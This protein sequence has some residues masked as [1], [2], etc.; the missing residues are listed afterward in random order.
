MPDPGSPH[1]C[2]QPDPTLE[3]SRFGVTASLD[4]PW[5][6]TVN[7]YW[8]HTANGT[9]ISKP[10][11]EYREQVIR[12]VE[13]LGFAGAFRST[14]RLECRIE[15]YPPDH[16]KRDL[17]NLPKAVLDSLHH[18]GM[19]V[20]DEQIDELHVSRGPVGG[21]YITVHISNLTPPNGSRT[22]PKGNSTKKPK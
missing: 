9:K 6:P 13:D 19:F 17:D 20:D 18:A 4:L 2:P 1:D 15:T 21:G 16:R 5:P 7:T 22:G 10:G 8:R 3:N 14:D 11:R 12:K